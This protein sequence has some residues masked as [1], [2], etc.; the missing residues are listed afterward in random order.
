MRCRGGAT[1]SAARRLVYVV[2]G[3]TD[4]VLS[5]ESV[6]PIPVDVPGPPARRVYRELIWLEAKAS[7]AAIVILFTLSLLGL[8]FTSEQWGFVLVGAPF[9]VSLYIIPDIYLINKHF[10]P[11]A[12]ALSRLDR[13]EK[14]APAEASAAVARALNLPLLSFLRISI[15]HGPV[16]TASIMISFAILNN[17]GAGIALWQQLIFAGTAL[18]FSAPTHAMIEF[19]TITRQMAAPIARLA[20]FSG[21]SMLPEHQ[22]RLV[23][24]RLRSKLFYLSICIAGLP[25]VFFGVSTGF[26]VNHLLWTGGTG[27]SLDQLVPLWRWIAGVVGI[28]LVL[29]FAM[30]ILTAAEA[31][32]L[33]S[34][35]SAALRRVERGSLDADLHITST[36]EHADLFR[37]FNHMIRGLREEVRLLEVTQAMAGELNLDILIQQIMSAASDLLD[38]ER[39]TLFLYDAKTDELWSRYAA[40]LH[41]GE[42][43][44]PSHAGIAGAVFTTGRT[45]NILDGYA[46][47]RF[48]PAIDRATG[49]HTRS[50]LCMR[51]STMPA[52]GSG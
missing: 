15:V 39:A 40:G 44:I 14:P 8:D 16:A 27:L 31:S 6:P 20:P 12:V 45:E 41:T 17:F 48:D 36:D 24:I 2:S 10:R 37:G 33:A 25:L 50:I 42:I 47:P 49:Y 34:K 1:Q 35:L 30:V 46:D 43:R 13:G 4:I 51:S 7:G 5:R 38:A 28:C 9:C 22:S 19:F 32:R 3:L 21:N 18:L 23:S 52:R 29:T 26:K 11:I